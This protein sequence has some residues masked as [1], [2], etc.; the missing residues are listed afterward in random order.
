MYLAVPVLRRQN[1]YNLVATLF[2]STATAPS[3]KIY[4]VLLHSIR[5][6]G[7][8]PHKLPLGGPVH[9]IEVAAIR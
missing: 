3:L 2:T 9:T 1:W 7:S 6:Q 8:P 4:N 5:S